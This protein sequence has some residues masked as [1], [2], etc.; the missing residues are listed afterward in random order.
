MDDHLTKPFTPDALLAVVA[1]AAH[2]GS[3]RGSVI[4]PPGIPGLEALV[5][6]DIPLSNT[7]APS[8]D[9]NGF[10]APAAVIGSELLV[11]DPAGFARTAAFLAPDAVTL[12]LQTIRVRCEDLRSG[13]TAMT[14]IAPAGS[15]LADAAHALAGSA[16]MFGFDRLAAV[17][18][19]F[20]QAVRT[21]S[22]DAYAH[23]HGLAAAISASLQAMPNRAGPSTPRL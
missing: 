22:P 23:A 18:R 7:S 4:T 21:S 6:A 3:L 17:A 13:L 9:P 20:E 19:G 2:V 16:G 14:T 8:T 12:Y 1:R 10:S 5:E 15:D 11:L